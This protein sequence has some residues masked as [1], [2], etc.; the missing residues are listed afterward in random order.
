M[1][2]WQTHGGSGSAPDGSCD[3]HRSGAIEL[4]FYDELGAVERDSVAGHLPACAVCRQAIHELEIIR[5]ALAARP[6]VSAPLSG[7]WSGF[8]ARLDS[9]LADRPGADDAAR[10]VALRPKVTVRRPYVTLFAMA[11]LLALVTMSVLFVQRSRQAPSV[12]QRA[13]DRRAAAT[14]A[15]FPN[16]DP[17]NLSAV[18]R[19]HLERSKLVL[20]GLANKDAGE[21]SASDWNYE[22]E[23]ATR[24]LSDTRLYRQTAEARGMTTLAGILRDLELVLLQTSMT[25]GTDPAD[26]PQ[27]QRAIRKRDLLHKMEM[28][29]TAGM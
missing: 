28:A 3:V 2:G 1:T 10:V 24:L 25:E 14:A 9:A 23:L 20:L 11:A 16:G 13:E 21:T 5:A 6:A 18:G 27:I 19:E 8:I 29:R 12:D 15:E 22:R 17:A 26:L 4:Y 7:D